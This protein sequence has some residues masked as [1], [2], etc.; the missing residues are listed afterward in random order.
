MT[1]QGRAAGTYSAFE[2]R[3]LDA[4]T[5]FWRDHDRAHLALVA[6]DLDGLP[7]SVNGLVDTGIRKW[8]S[9]RGWAHNRSGVAMR[10]LRRRNPE[11]QTICERIPRSDAPRKRFS[12]VRNLGFHIV[13]HG[14]LTAA[15]FVFEL[16]DAFGRRIDFRA[17]NPD[18]EFALSSLGWRGPRRSMGA[19]DAFV[20]E[21]TVSTP[22]AEY[23]NTA[24]FS[25][26]IH[27]NPEAMLSFVKSDE[28]RFVARDAAEVLQLFPENARWADK[29]ALNAFADHARFASDL[30]LVKVWRPTGAE[31]EAKMMV[32]RLVADGSR[33]HGSVGT[34]PMP[35]PSEQ[36]FRFENAVVQK[37][38]TVVVDGRLMVFEEAADPRY[39][40]VAGQYDT[41]FGSSISP[42]QALVHL[43]PVE[44]LS[45]REGVLLSGRNDG[46][47]Y[48]WVIEY[49]PRLM[50]LQKGLPE[51]IPLIVTD[52]TPKSGIE[53]L[54]SLTSRPLLT[55]NSDRA[56]LVEV[57]HVVAPP[58][59]VL[60]STEVPWADGIRM[61]PEPLLSL[62]ERVLTAVKST[63]PTRRIFLR[64]RSSHRGLV[65]EPDLAK[66]A[67]ELGFEAVDPGSMTWQEQLEL[68]SSASILVGAS[69]AV[70]ANYLFMARGSRILAL[71]SVA[72]H[73]FVLPAALAEV[74]G[75]EFSYLLGPNVSPLESVTYRRDWIHSSFSIDPSAF[76]RALLEE[77]AA[78]RSL[79]SDPVLPPVR[80]TLGIGS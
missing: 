78:E 66:I 1:R 65:N 70:M 75:A 61:N 6:T 48:H 30:D 64:R 31:P 56:H 58:V 47:W 38:A 54:R 42:D 17:S 46:N 3:V 77:L 55:L 7:R 37:G 43:Y 14:A 10:R 12:P 51:D 62:R 33:V 60:D 18:A 69:G 16:Y 2:R 49:L 9:V 68:F 4:I 24:W 71:T 28:G 72:L 40:F 34:K 76:Q 29:F 20:D 67:L 15:P 27:R 73:D 26:L 32:P 5:D 21:V 59:Q 25:T 22:F 53:L 57:L 41:V 74:A 23:D 19:P 36:W 44:T 11:Y 13:A 80:R 63:V 79:Q 52:R 50:M 39:D 8:I 35:S 45:V